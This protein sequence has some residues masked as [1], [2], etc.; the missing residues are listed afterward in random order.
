MTYVPPRGSGVD[1][2]VDPLSLSPFLVPKETWRLFPLGPDEGI[3]PCVVPETPVP[4]PLSP[5]GVCPPPLI[6][7][8]SSSAKE[9]LRRETK[10]P[11]NPDLHVYLVG[12]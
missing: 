1:R 9:E 2:D 7:R 4:S 11:S 10:P 5:A 6:A 3:G 12:F 8:R